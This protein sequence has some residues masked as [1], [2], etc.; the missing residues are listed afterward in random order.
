M[1]GSNDVELPLRSSAII[2]IENDDKY[3]FLWSILANLHP[4]KN[5]HPN[6]VSNYRQYFDEI[7]IQGFDFT[8]GFKSSD[9]YIFEKLNN[10]SINKFEL[11]F[12]QDENKWKHKIISIETSKNE[13]EK[14][15][16]LLIYK[17][18][19][20]LIKKTIFLGKHN[21]KFVCRR[22]LSSYSSQNVLIKHKQRCNQQ[23]ITSIKTSNES[24]LDWKTLS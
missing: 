3:C 9:L 22:C 21:S 10:L 2:H 14:V 23:E 7:N 13:S 11:S 4:C 8:N 1:H 20:V 18:N 16:D 19:Y 24:H 6:R 15:I 5:N 12:Y 17:N